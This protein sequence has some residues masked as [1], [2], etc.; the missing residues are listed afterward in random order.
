MLLYKEWLATNNLPC[1]KN[2][3]HNDFRLQAIKQLLATVTEHANKMHSTMTQQDF[4][5]WVGDILYNELET[6]N[7]EGLF[8]ISAKSV[9]RATK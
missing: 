5:V 9:V 6:M 4:L 2:L 3:T 1:K 8:P 7:V